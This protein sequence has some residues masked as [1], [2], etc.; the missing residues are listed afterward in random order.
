M[1][2][3]LGNEGYGLRPLV[4][5]Q[6]TDILYIPKLITDSLNQPSSSSLGLESLNVAVACGIL[7]YQLLENRLTLAPSKNIY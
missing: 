5:K 3:L 4:A 7:L 1:K 6:C 2:Y